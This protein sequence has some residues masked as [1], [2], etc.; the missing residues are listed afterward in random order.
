MAGERDALNLLLVGF[1]LGQ[2]VG[3]YEEQAAGLNGPDPA[4]REFLGSSKPAAETCRAPFVHQ[5]SG[6]AGTRPHT[7]SLPKGGRGEMGTHIPHPSSCV[8]QSLQ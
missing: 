7:H 1:P 3:S 4:A 2:L 5:L 8:R 6:K